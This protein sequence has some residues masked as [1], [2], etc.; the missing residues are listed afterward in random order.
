MPIRFFLTRV[1]TSW[2]LTLLAFGLPFGGC[3]VAKPVYTDSP[4][5]HALSMGIWLEVVARAKGK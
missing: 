4:V 5:G 2:T 3:R 1:L